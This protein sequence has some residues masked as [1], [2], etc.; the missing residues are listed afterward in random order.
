ML[1]IRLSDIP[2]TL[3]ATNL[4]DSPLNLMGLVTLQPGKPTVVELARLSPAYRQALYTTL[5]KAVGA[6]TVK[7]DLPK[8]APVV[9]VRRDP[10]AAQTAREAEILAV[11]VPAATGTLE[12]PEPPSAPSETGQPPSAPS[13]TG[14]P[15]F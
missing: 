15:P 8:L 14:Q 7:A 5:R 3:E 10:S 9:A 1:D 4:L 12:Q 11:G 2:A 13:E 6:G